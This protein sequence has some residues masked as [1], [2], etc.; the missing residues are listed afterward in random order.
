M[1]IRRLV[2]LACL[3]LLIP[4]SGLAAQTSPEDFAYSGRIPGPLRASGLYR[5]HLSQDI[6]G[7]CS[8]TCSD[9]RVFDPRGVEVPYVIVEDRKPGQA[10][11]SYLLEVVG[12]EEKASS[13]VI[14]LKMPDKAEPVSHLLFG[15]GEKDFRKA[16]LI[17]A[18]PDMKSWSKLGEDRIYDFSSQVDL[19]KTAVSFSASGARYLR[20]TVKDEEEGVRKGSEVS[21]KYEGLDFRISGLAP[22]KVRISSFSALTGPR[23]KEQVE[24]DTQ[25]LEG[26]S[27]S[28]DKDGNTVITFETGLPF[29]R[30]S[31]DLSNGY[32]YRNISAYGSDTGKEG[33]FRLLQQGSLYRFLLADASEQRSSLEI[34]SSGSRYFRIVIQNRNNPPLDIRGI[35]LSWVRRHMLFAAL[36][37]AGE[38]SVAFGNTS[39]ASP[40]YDLSRSINQSNW[41]TSPAE[42]AA[43]SGIS[44]NELFSQPVPG[45]VKAKR[46]K[47]ILVLVVCCLVAG[48]GVWL[49]RLL[50]KSG[51]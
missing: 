40:D 27:V 38:Y 49:Y 6:L 2:L 32:Y 34:Q 22:K 7:R 50:A 29:T 51:R 46:E 42:Q 16:V 28:K 31:F 9:V 11:R 18:G 41:E 23:E 37:D 47:L 12:F 24:Y 35:A 3:L 20:V 36:A 43:V 13:I 1:R 39:V 8:S 30:I 10:P 14:V 21:L 5:L 19:R 45:G 26:Y 33:T 44:K 48:M 25:R 15:M 4:I 17:E